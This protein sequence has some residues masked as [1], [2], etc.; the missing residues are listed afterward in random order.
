MAKV[1]KIRNQRKSATRD[2]V[3]AASIAELVDID[4]SGCPFIEIDGVQVQADLLTH[5]LNEKDIDAGKLPTRVLVV[6]PDGKSRPVIVGLVSSTVNRDVSDLP[7]RPKTAALDGNKV[8]L[9][10]NKEIVL[11]CGASSITLTK[12]GN[13]VIRGKKVT[14]RASGTNKVKGATVQ[15][16]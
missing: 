1:S 16:N 14:S 10:A 7:T 6:Q 15:I 8:V 13:I 12:E 9:D 2:S 4:S 11:R 3:A 5:L